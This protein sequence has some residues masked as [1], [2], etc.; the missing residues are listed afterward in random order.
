MASGMATPPL[1]VPLRS[2]R[3]IC[4]Y[5]AAASADPKKVK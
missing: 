2:W 5:T 1:A 3:G 4:W